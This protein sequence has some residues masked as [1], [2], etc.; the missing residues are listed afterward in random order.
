MKK[1]LLCIVSILVVVF[2]SNAEETKAPDFALKNPDG[3][4]IKLSDFRGK[5]VVLNFWGHGVLLVGR[6]FQIL[7][8]CTTI[9]EIKGWK[10]LG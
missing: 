10:Y 2:C 8:G 3:K 5:V 9:T 4:V 6:S 1:I 7:S